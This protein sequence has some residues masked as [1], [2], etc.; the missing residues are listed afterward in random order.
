VF[1]RTGDPSASDALLEQLLAAFD[2]IA[3]FP[4]LG[5]SRDD[6]RRGLRSHL[7]GNHHVFYRTH[8]DYVE[9]TRVIHQRRDL[10]RAFA[11][12]RRK[13]NITP[14]FEQFVWERVD[15][16]EYASTDH[17]LTA[18]MSALAEREDRSD[19]GW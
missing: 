6:V 9:V 17:V 1:A 16:E 10:R 12:K 14:E 11:R 8:R 7:A 3:A 18:C 4:R 15:S 2:L 13:I 19:Q 5:T